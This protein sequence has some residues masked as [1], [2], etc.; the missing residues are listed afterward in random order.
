MKRVD[1]GP[2]KI[3]HKRVK[4]KRKTSQHFRV[5]IFSLILLPQGAKCRHGSITSPH[6]GSRL[7]MKQKKGAKRSFSYKRSC[8]TLDD[9]WWHTATGAVVTSVNRRAMFAFCTRRGLTVRMLEALLRFPRFAGSNKVNGTR[10]AFWRRVLRLPRVTSRKT[11]AMLPT[12][13]SVAFKSNSL[14]SGMR[15]RKR[16]IEDNA[17]GRS[18]S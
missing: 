4:K 13:E 8:V 14:I 2:I 17:G 1:P 11:T 3:H 6:Q 9:K 16:A 5:F 15:K 12:L 10:G 18:L 7:E